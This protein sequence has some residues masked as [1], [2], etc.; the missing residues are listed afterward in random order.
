MG[1]AEFNMKEC[2]DVVLAELTDTNWTNGIN[3]FDPTTVVIESKD[4]PTV[5]DSKM[6]YTTSLGNVL[7]AVLGRERF[8]RVGVAAF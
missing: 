1:A 8:S 4:L 2:S 3:N 6:Q 7:H 5:I